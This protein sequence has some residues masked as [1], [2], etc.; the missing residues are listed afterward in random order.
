LD[1]GTARAR[2]ANCADGSKMVIQNKRGVRKQFL[3]TNEMTIYGFATKGEKLADCPSLTEITDSII[4]KDVEGL[5]SISLSGSSR[6]VE[7]PIGRQKFIGK[8]CEWIDI[9]QVRTSGQGC[10]DGSKFVISK[11][12]GTR[13][14]FLLVEGKDIIAFVKNGEKFVDCSVFT[15][16]TSQVSCKAVPGVDGILTG[17]SAAPSTTPAPSPTP[18]APSPAPAAPSPTPASSTGKILQC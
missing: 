9:N 10:A 12:K 11:E 7:G 13:K 2:G 18:V 4:C 6:V 5:S 8:A 14:Q 17:G 16:V 3:L 1:F 15:E